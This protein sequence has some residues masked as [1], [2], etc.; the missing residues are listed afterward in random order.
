[1][2]TIKVISFIQPITTGL[3]ERPLADSTKPNVD[4]LVIFEPATKQTMSVIQRVLQFKDEYPEAF[5]YVLELGRD[6]EIL[7]RE[8]EIKEMER[9][10]RQTT[11]RADW[12]CERTDIDSLVLAP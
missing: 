3:V 10:H 6:S 7:R 2:F 1:M 11:G 8:R 5:E 9:A 4:S 12:W